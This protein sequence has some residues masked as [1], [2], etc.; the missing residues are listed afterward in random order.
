MPTQD[1]FIVSPN[2]EEQVIA[3]KAFISA[4]KIKFEV[5]T[6][7]EFYNPEM[8][9]KIEKSRQEFKEGKFTRVP[10]EDINKFLGL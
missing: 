5:T 6:H 4:L 1:V 9:A 10:K 7:Q 3:L 8:V 2:T